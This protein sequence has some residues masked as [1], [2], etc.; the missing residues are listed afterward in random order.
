ME[1]EEPRFWNA[2]YES[3]FTLEELRNADRETQKEVIRTWFFANYE[4]P[5]ERTP[6]ESREGGYIYIWGGPYDAYEEIS[7]VFEEYLPDDVIQ[8]LVD[9]LEQNCLVWTSAPR[10][11]DY[12]DYYSSVL[13]SNTE[14]HKTLVENLEKVNALLDLEVDEQLR[15]HHLRL[16][17]INVI[18]ALESFL[19]DGF[20]T[21]VM[22]DPALI[23]KF[24][25]TNPDFTKQKFP[26]SEL[27]QKTD[28]IEDEV[29]R[30]LRSLLWH[31]LEKIKPMYKKTLDIEFPENLGDLHRAILTRH[32]LVHRNG[33]TKD[34]KEIPLN[35]S[36]VSDL[37]E[38][39]RTFG[40]HVD[41]QFE[42]NLNHEVEF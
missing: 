10:D 39:V 26:L 13:L 27:F 24:V 20:I 22:S 2:E 23:R 25:E 15:Q 4:D 28:V 29:K 35:R 9:E 18:T 37:I 36:H 42:S 11:N 31:N 38:L 41:G 30:Y 33:K 7:R 5:A 14:F 34:D 16:L 40:E 1:S 12:D 6:Y 8:E 17:H 32:D 19:S 3:S 21:T